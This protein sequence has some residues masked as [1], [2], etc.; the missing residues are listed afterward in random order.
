MIGLRAGDF[1]DS[2]S[3]QLSLF[4]EVKDLKKDNKTDK[5]IDEIN[6]KYGKNIIKKGALK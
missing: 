3:Y 4:E 6:N 1:T 5:L 2:N